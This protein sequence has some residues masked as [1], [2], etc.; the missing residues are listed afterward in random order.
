MD[1]I[2]ISFNHYLPSYWVLFKDLVNDCRKTK[3]KVKRKLLF[4]KY[5]MDIAHIIVKLIREKSMLKINHLNINNGMFRDT[6]FPLS[7]FLHN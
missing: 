4:I 5:N 6:Q 7:T 2:Y 1:G 3:V